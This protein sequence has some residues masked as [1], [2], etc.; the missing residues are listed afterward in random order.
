MPLA[1]VSAGIES[2]FSFR[3]GDDMARLFWLAV[4]AGIA[5]A[6]VGLVSWI[7]AYTT[8]AKLLRSPPPRMGEQSVSLLWR[9]MP[10]HPDHPR[11]WR[12][13]FGPT[14]IPGAPRVVIYVGPTGRL[15]RTEPADLAA[16]VNAL[17]NRGY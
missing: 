4:M 3:G 1:Q 14:A 6:V 5:G 10:N 13:A 9:G 11:A 12:F 17:H 2:P 7:A 8:V 15:I 16:R